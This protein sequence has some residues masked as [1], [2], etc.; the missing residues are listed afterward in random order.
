MI[1][2]TGGDAVGTVSFNVAVTPCFSTWAACIKTFIFQ[3]IGSLLNQQK[4]ALG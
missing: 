1:R 3:V 4:L 2:G